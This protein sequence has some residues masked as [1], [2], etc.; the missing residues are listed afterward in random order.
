MP[1]YSD[2]E[3]PE[4]AAEDFGGLPGNYIIEFA[5]GSAYPGRQSRGGNRVRAA[6]NKWGR[7]VSA[8]SFMVDHR[9][10]ECVRADR[11]VSAVERLLDDGVTLRNQ[12]W[13]GIP[14]LCRAG[15]GRR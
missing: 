15:R 11:E 10:D 7:A 5:D 3:H 14:N 4:T 13:P 6:I 1:R 8:V 9:D 2:P 12:R